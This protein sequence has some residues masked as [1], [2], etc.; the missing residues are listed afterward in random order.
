MEEATTL[1]R[2][3]SLSPFATNVASSV[4]V[5]VLVSIALRL[6]GRVLLKRAGEAEARFRL[7]KVISYTAWTLAIFLLGLIWLEGFRDLSMFLGLLSAGLAVALQR[8]ITNIAGFVFIA[9]H[10]P[11]RAGD[12]IQI[13]GVRGDVLDVQ[14]FQTTLLEVGNWVDADQSTGR[15]ITMPNYRVFEDHQANYSAVFDFIWNEVS[16]VVTFDSDWK[17]AK[18]IIEG[19]AAAEYELIRA[20]TEE[21]RQRAENEHVIQYR[22]LTPRVYTSVVDRGVRL[23][24]R[25]LSSPRLRRDS[26]QRVWEAVLTAFESRDDIK[27]AVVES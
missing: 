23:T 4:A 12:R 5:V 20:S 6:V 7:R 10:K 11:F 22:N 16:L 13:A 17:G 1:E 24:L 14:L 21:A 2:M 26:E 3:G 18:Q 15:I 27:F 9:W 8:P 25:Y 19:I